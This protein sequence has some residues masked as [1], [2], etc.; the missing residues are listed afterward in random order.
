MVYV[1]CVHTATEHASY[2]QLDIGQ[3]RFYVLPRSTLQNLGFESVG[4]VTVEKLSDGPVPWE[5]LASAIAAAAT[6]ED[7]DDAP[8]WVD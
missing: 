8:W 7:R 6:G 5:A 3:W 1:F 4:L 2:D